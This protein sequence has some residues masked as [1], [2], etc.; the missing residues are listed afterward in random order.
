MKSFRL[1]LL[2][3][4]GIVVVG[5]AALIVAFAALDPNK[6][7]ATLVD[8]VHR[9]TGRD[10]TVTG[11][12]HLRLGLSPRFE[13]DDI[14]FANPA[15][16][17]RPQMLTAKS[18]TAELALLP[19]LGGDAVISSLTLQD[20]DIALERGADGTG[21]WQ[22][23]PVR[24]AL[25][26]AQ[27]G[28]GSG[29]GGGASHHVEIRSIR[30]EGGRLTWQTPQAAPQVFAITHLRWSSAGPDLPMS[31]AFEGS[32][33]DVP[34]TLTA[35]SGSLQR[36]QGGPVSAL[37]G[38][39]PLTV[40]AAA[41]GATVH[42]EG[43]ISHPDQA[44]G[45]QFRLTAT[46]H[47]LDGLEKLAGVAKLPPLAD[48]TATAL[49]SDGPAG[50]LRTSQVSV[51]A[52]ASDLGTWATGLA[53]KQL[54][55]S[56][57]GPGQLAQLNVDGT[58]QDQPLRLA[59]TAT[60]PDVVGTGGPI[61]ATITAQA[62][63]ANL[64][65]HGTMPPS[66]GASGLDMTVSLHAPEVAALSPLIGR[67]LPA[68][69]DFALD[70]QVGDAG[71]KLR[72]VAIRNLMIASSIGDATGELT[73]QW[74]PRAAITGSLTSN[75]L[76]LDAITAP[77]GGVL[78]AVWPLP[79]TS[80][81]G[82]EV[83]A[84]P[85]VPPTPSTGAPPANPAPP[86]QPP[87]LPLARLRTTDA[88]VALAVAN[89]TVAGQHLQDLQAH[90][91]LADGKLALNPFRAQSPDGAIIGGISLDASSDDPP[92]AVTLRSPSIS[93]AA[94]ADLLGY[95]GGTTGT[96]QIDAQLSGV[97]QTLPALKATL[98][99]HLG[100]AM[101]NGQ[102]D[103]ALI[104]GLIGTALDT[105]GVPSFGGGTSQVRCLALRM[106][107]TN[108]LGRI[109]ALA[110]D[111]SKLTIDGEGEVNLQDQT[112]DLHLRPRIRLGPTEVAAPVWLHGAFGQMTAAL[113]PVLGGG[114]V[115]MSI[116]GAPAGPS[117]CA[118]KLALARGGLTGPM[119]P[120]APPADQPFVIRKPK[121]LLQGL[122]H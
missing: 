39:W 114:R 7:R 110:A 65:A 30:L 56:A 112:A 57:P 75:V 93:A 3:L 88:D 25:F 66:L 99:G 78:P 23:V 81:G 26:P 72:G 18:L 47:T 116:G 109:R 91:Q 44:R 29:E 17:S 34:L 33:D 102:V 41:L 50:E 113:D 61:Q 4:G 54:Q 73:V 94:V 100:L 8:S 97:G 60:Q 64:S 40:D 13:V 87:L 22:F 11:P 15:G 21:N 45:F 105:A 95:P 46:A 48:V 79:G 82:G 71:V 122:F 20:A 83:V 31:L 5:V 10:L 119:P 49:L 108:G 38:A 68:A 58:Y 120:S 14:A 121:D 27:A 52:G 9:A 76:D 37:A 51:H 98:D 84:M 101:V 1:L 96:M 115:G 104:Q 63:G 53:I 36:L 55:F 74:A 86:A 118:S 28:T 117:A 69:H 19:L 107:F 77:A 24:H 90:F 32:K 16:A 103:D 70:A 6:L 2:A 62:A 92:I 42:L 59:G 67:A 12:V 43:G 80:G 111:T 85:Q 89:L 106:D 35:N